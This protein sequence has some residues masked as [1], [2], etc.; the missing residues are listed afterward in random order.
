MIDEMLVIDGLDLQSRLSTFDATQEVSY[1]KIIT[2]L[3]DTEHPYT[4]TLRPVLTFSLLPATEEEDAELYETLKRLVFNVEYTERGVEVARK[5]RL[6]SNLQSVFLLK[7]SDG[8]KRYKGGEIQ[9]R[10]L[11]SIMG[12]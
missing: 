6:V 11:S 9:L 4:G 3:D 8:K 5:M 1:K 10:A 7:S 2:T 12:V